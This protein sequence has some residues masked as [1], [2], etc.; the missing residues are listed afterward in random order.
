MN[1]GGRMSAEWRWRWRRE[2][3]RFER[4]RKGGIRFGGRERSRR[5]KEEEEGGDKEGEV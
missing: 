5:V 2:K 1:E 3:R 4:G